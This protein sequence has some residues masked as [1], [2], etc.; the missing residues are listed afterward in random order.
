MI[1]RGTE[2]GEK[3]CKKII[4]KVG[5]NLAMDHHNEWLLPCRN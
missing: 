1:R 4:K 3:D 2:V 5:G